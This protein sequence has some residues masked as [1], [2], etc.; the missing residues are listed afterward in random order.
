MTVQINCQPEKPHLKAKK[1]DL[2]A[3]CKYEMFPEME[4]EFKKEDYEETMRVKL[5]ATEYQADSYYFDKRLELPYGKIKVTIKTAAKQT[6][7]QELVLQA[8]PDGEKF[9]VKIEP[10]P[11]SL[12]TLRERHEL[13]EAEGEKREQEARLAQKR[14]QELKQKIRY[15]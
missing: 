12:A 5:N 15:E 13:E 1:N 7:G 11:M 9:D 6:D 4:G 10:E 14:T 3:E 8:L 2:Y